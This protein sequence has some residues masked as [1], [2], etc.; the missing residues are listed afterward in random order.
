MDNG[1]WQYRFFCLEQN[2]SKTFGLELYDK[3]GTPI[4]YLGIE[5]TQEYALIEQDIQRLRETAEAVLAAI[6]KPL[7]Q[8]KDSR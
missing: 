6:V 7:E 3:H 4:G 2:L 5:K 1:L 8:V